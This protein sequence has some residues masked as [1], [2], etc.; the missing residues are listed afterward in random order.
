MSQRTITTIALVTIAFYCA[1]FAKAIGRPGGMLLDDQGRP[2]VV[3]YVAM[4]A[5]GSLALQ[6]HP[7]AA[8]DQIAHKNAQDQGLGF[9]TEQTFPFAYPPTYF[10]LVTPFALLPYLASLVAFT[11][12][13][14]ALYALV[15]ANIVGRPSAAIWMLA[16]TATFWNVAVGQNGLMNAA[17][18]GS[19][20]LLIPFRP[21]LAGF[22]LGLLS[23]KPHVGLLVP[24]ALVASGAWRPFLAAAVTTLCLAIVSL[25]IFGTAPW[26]AF[27]GAL[28]DF[29]G[30]VLSNAYERV[31]RLQSLFG[32]LRSFGVS[33]FVALATQAAWA[34]ILAFA[35]TLFWR[36]QHPYELKAA[37]LA[38]ASVMLS[39]YLF[40]YDFA[41]LT[42]A[43]AFLLRHILATGISIPRIAPLLAANLLIAA[44]PLLKVP[45]GFLAAAMLAAAI[46]LEAGILPLAGSRFARKQARPA[47]SAATTG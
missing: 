24:L 32:V 33:P 38:T 46:A 21:W 15:N 44:F 6:G 29:G 27:L 25:V 10:L 26:L 36:G 47:P 28:G 42:I 9:D 8:Y 2:A 1:L 41:V 22:L 18:L 39:P 43:Q 40:I 23:Y 7:E 19:G 11:L 35:V 17:L 16:T 31:H 30:L 45:T 34:A 5:A 3:D 4:W 20:L 37:A 12:A 14:L 13:T